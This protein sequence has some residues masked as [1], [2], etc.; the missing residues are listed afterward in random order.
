V[1]VVPPTPLTA[2]EFIAWAEGRP[3]RYE[4]VDGEI[5]AQASE[6]LA[7]AKMKLA[8]AIALG[9]AIRKRGAPCHV[10][11]DNMAVRVDDRAVFEPDAGLLRT[12]TRSVDPARRKPDHRRRGPVAFDGPQRRSRQAR[13]LFPPRERPALPSSTRTSRSSSTTRAGR[14][15]IF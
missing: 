4:L 14:G 2:G 10:L 7:H 5:F 9:D 12:R 6:R 1:G 3:E 15:S 11:P 13:R 8:V